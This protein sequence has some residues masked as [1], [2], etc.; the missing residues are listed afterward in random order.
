METGGSLPHSQELSTCP[1]LMEHQSGPHHPILFLQH[2]SFAIRPPTSWSPSGLL[3]SYFLTYNPYA[4]VFSPIRTKYLVNL[5]VPSRDHSNDT[6]RRVPSANVLV[7][8]YS[9]SFHHF[10]PLRNK[11]SPSAPSSQTPS[12]Y[13]PPLT[14]ETKFHTNREPQAKL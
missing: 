12:V 5:N 4:F 7:M 11:Y 9:P 2:P 14:S 13:V 10:I 3:L 1:H 6:L 8:K